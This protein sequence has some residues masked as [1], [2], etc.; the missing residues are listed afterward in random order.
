VEK[1]IPKTLVCHICGRSYGLSSLQ[2]H[3]PNC[4]KMFVDLESKK[5]FEQRKKLPSI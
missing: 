2:I 3:L 4:I 1:S 5:P